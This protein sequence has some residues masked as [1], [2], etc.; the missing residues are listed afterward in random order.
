MNYVLVAIATLF[1]S[2]SSFAQG[3][4]CEISDNPSQNPKIVLTGETH[5]IPGH[6]DQNPEAIAGK[7]SLEILMAGALK[8]DF[9]LAL[10]G[11]I[12]GD[13]AGVKKF[14]KSSGAHFSEP[15]QFYVN[16]L[17]NNLVNQLT[18]LGTKI[19]RAGGQVNRYFSTGSQDYFINTIVE[20]SLLF[21]MVNQR[22]ET[23]EA[24]LLAF[25][26][27]QESND[28]DLK[29]AFN[30][31]KKYSLDNPETYLQ[32]SKLYAQ[33]PSFHFKMLDAF[34]LVLEELSD[35]LLTPE[36]IEKYE[37]PASLKTVMEKYKDY[38][39]KAFVCKITLGY[40]NRI[41]EKNIKS[42]YCQAKA[43]GKDLVVR[44]GALHTPGLEKVLNNTIGHQ[45]TIESTGGSPVTNNNSQCLEM[46]E[47]YDQ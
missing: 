26:K 39:F 18:T 42:L 4:E 25:T 13:L 2:Q 29:A 17:E 28:S 45:V 5:F 37:T 6:T 9:F 10:E 43:L 1:F 33:D 31:I 38:D 47:N 12:Y 14:M 40:R 30:I 19:Y 15:T 24:F 35:R 3:L 44:T 46:A 21:N 27:A 20:E 41:F 32:D 7:N 8:G 16:G 34:I 23:Q 36:N 22:T 11:P